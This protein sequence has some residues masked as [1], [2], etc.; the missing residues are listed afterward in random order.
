M[1]MTNSPSPIL[2]TATPDDAEAIAA[3]KVLC[4]RE[5]Y[6]GLMPKASL[7]GL[8]AADEVFHWRDWL[9]DENAGLVAHLLWLDETLVGYGLAGPMRLGDR[10][11]KEIEADGELY[12]LYIHPDHQRKGFGQRILSSLVGAMVAD[13]YRQIGAWMI[14]GNVRAEQFYLKLGA[15][16]VCKRVEIHHG[17]I[18]YRE[19]SWIWADLPKLTAKLTIRSV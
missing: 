4:W 16:E 10:P 2:S 8:D 18:S 14:G 19:K 1:F 9:Q 7:A 5:A 13:G 12:A 17:R 6:V 3:L 11:G 15:Q